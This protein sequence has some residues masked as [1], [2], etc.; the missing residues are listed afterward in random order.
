MYIALGI[1]I[2]MMVCV[3]VEMRR[4]KQNVFMESVFARLLGDCRATSE[5]RHRDA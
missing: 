1:I 3:A 2:A 5:A 4:I